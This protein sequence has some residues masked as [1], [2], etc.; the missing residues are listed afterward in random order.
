MVFIS[1]S[2]L[3]VIR[4]EMYGYGHSSYEFWVWGF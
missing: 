3:Y 2:D 4:T 1:S